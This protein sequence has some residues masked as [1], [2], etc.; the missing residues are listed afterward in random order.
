MYK[1]L[2]SNGKTLYHIPVC[3]LFV[4]NKNACYHITM[5]INEHYSQIK[6]GA[7][8]FFFFLNKKKKRW[9]GNAENRNSY[10]HNQTFMNHINFEN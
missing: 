4:L 9:Q 8:F 5:Q 3:R 2:V 1:I 6:K 7:F 10:D